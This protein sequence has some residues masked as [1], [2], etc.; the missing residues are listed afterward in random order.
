[1]A[2]G[3]FFKHDVVCKRDCCFFV[4]MASVV[5]RH[6]CVMSIGGLSKSRGEVEGSVVDWSCP[7]PAPSTMVAWR[8]GV[9]ISRV[10]V[11]CMPKCRWWQAC[12]GGG[13][14]IDLPA[15]VA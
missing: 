7:C 4:S 12:H 10:R 2:I 3:Y 8:P 6:G 5:G 15:L 14:R 13:G 1:M 9:S 11:R